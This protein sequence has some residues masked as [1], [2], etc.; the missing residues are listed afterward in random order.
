MSSI[1]LFFII[2]I[3]APS[4]TVALVALAFYLYEKRQDMEFAKFVPDKQHRKLLTS[5]GLRQ[6]MFKVFQNEPTFDTISFVHFIKSYSRAN[7]Y[8]S[9]KYILPNNYLNHPTY[10]SELLAIAQRNYSENL[11]LDS[12]L[13]FHGRP[14]VIE[15]YKDG[16]IIFKYLGLKGDTYTFK[17]GLLQDWILRD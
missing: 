8:E 6:K 14:A 4:A 11:T 3:G 5:L 2:L 1:L 12:M 13:L 17:Q 7:P 15:T 9:F 10:R 16:T